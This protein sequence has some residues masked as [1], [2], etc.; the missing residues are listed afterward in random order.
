M[1]NGTAEFRF[2][3]HRRIFFEMAVNV[4]TMCENGE[5]AKRNECT[6]DGK[7]EKTLSHWLKSG[8]EM[9]LRGELQ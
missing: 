9:N 4:F 7:E 3:E 6:G 1:G 2:Y 8:K 5:F